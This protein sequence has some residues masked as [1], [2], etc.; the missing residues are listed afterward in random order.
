ME[1]RNLLSF[2]AAADAGSIANAARVC[3]LSV[4]AVSKHIKELEA[5]LEAQLLTRSKNDVRLTD[6]GKVFVVRARNIINETKMAKEEMAAIKG[7]IC[8]EL[9]IGAGCFIEPFVGRAIAEFMRRYPKVRVMVQYNYAHELNRMLKD[10]E[11]DVAFSMNLPYTNEDI[12]SRACFSFYLYAVMSR[13]NVLAKFKRVTMEDL[14]QSN[15]IVPDAGKRELAT[16][17]RYFTEDVTQ[18]VEKSS[19]LCNNANAI[20]NGLEVLDAVTFLPKEYVTKRPHLVAK[21]IDGLNKQMTSN[22]HWLRCG[23]VKA[24]VAAFLSIIDEQ[25]NKD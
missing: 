17:Q 1:I 13:K 19:C 11:I 3:H 5:E 10:K 12:E 15:I 8:G 22:A 21:R 20:L 14:M 6:Y 4:S 18:I 7:E 24:A 16:I 2:V 23:N 25:F 9:R